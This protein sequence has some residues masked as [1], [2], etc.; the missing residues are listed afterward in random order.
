[1]HEVPYN[2]ISGCRVLGAV[3]ALHGIEDCFVIVHSLMGCHSGLMLLELLQDQHNVRVLYSGV[4]Q[5]DIVYGT[6]HRLYKAILT[7][8]KIFNPRMIAVVEGNASALIGT[9]IEG[10]IEKIRREH[11]VDIP[12]LVFKGGGHTPDVKSGF[13]DALKQL[14]DL[15]ERKP[16][17][18][19]VQRSVNLIGLKPDEF[20]AKQDIVEIRRLLESLGIKVNAVVPGGTFDDVKR[21]GQAD[22]SVVI[23]GDGVAL[24]ELLQREHGVPYIVTVY[25]FGIENTRLFLEDVARELGVDLSFVS[26]I[27]EK[28]KGLIKSAVEKTYFSLKAL[29]HAAALIV[30]DP[31]KSLSLTRMLIEEFLVDVHALALHYNASS[32]LLERSGVDSNI[33][34]IVKPSQE[35]VEELAEESDIVFGSSLERNICRRLGIPLVRFSFPVTDMIALT[36]TPFAGFRGVI[37]WIEH[38]LNSTMCM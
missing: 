5:D 14:I 21:L 16:R 24:A 37:T 9:D 3:R 25:P 27:V 4:H 22:L 11:Y 12:I 20:K 28:E 30:G 1:M 32:Q 38:I 19:V 31:G 17:A 29:K 23:G 10:V 34:I 7:A 13:E 33:T 18:T 2:P 8:Y 6:E 26:K 35:K 36:D 15:V